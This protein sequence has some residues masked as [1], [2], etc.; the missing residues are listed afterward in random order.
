MSIALGVGGNTA[1]GCLGVYH[2]IS[3]IVHLYVTAKGNYRQ[4]EFC[5]LLV[6]PA[7][8]RTTKAHGETH[9]M[10]P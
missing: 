9:N 2:R 4:H 3:V 6:H 10:D 7:Q 5:A 8:Q 1:L